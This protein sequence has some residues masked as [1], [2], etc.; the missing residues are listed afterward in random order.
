MARSDKRWLGRDNSACNIGCDRKRERRWEM[1]RFHEVASVRDRRPEVRGCGRDGARE[2]TPRTRPRGATGGALT[3]ARGEARADDPDSAVAG[4]A[5]AAYDARA[6]VGGSLRRRVASGP[7]TL[8]GCAARPHSASP[9]ARLCRSISLRPARDGRPRTGC[10]SDPR[11]RSKMAVAT[12]SPP[13]PPLRASRRSEMAPR[14]GGG[15]K[16]E[17]RPRCSSGSQVVTG[18]AAGRS[19]R[20][21]SVGGGRRPGRP[22]PSGCSGIHG[23][24]PG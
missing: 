5:C 11:A 6:R 8:A 21:G 22:E 3:R 19:E 20:M 17:M 4:A 7:P 16:R 10:K 24:Q 12:P 14:D 23:V 9:R 2:P 15:A 13:L 1:R 18:R